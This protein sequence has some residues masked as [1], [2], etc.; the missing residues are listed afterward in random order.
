MILDNNPSAGNISR[1][2]VDGFEL[3]YGGR[4]MGFDVRASATAQ[5]PWDQ[6][7]QVQLQRVAKRF[8]S[9]GL[10][11]D[12]GKWRFGMNWRGSSER[13]DFLVT[14]STTPT[15]LAAYR[16]FDLTASY[17]F[18]QHWSLAARVENAFDQKYQLA[19][20]FNTAPTGVFMTLA[21]RQ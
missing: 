3:S 17:A 9:L 2:Q 21:Y 14:S 7:N 18:D 19:Q 13:R 8:G 16:V 6:V 5:N 1:A 4:I 11:R 15:Q 20:G 12:W 10:G